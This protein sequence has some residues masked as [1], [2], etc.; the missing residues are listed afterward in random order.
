MPFYIMLERHYICAHGVKFSC[1]HKGSRHA[2]AYC[3]GLHGTAALTSRDLEFEPAV[4][5]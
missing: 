5:R 1:P 3:M 4:D 2:L